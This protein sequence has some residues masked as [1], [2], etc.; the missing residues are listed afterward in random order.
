ME[1]KQIILTTL[2]TLVL[3]TGV[4]H[5]QQSELPQLNALKI[6]QIQVLGTHNSYARPVDPRLA[7]YADPI[8]AK[9]MEKMTTLI[10]ADK[11][12]SFKE[13]HPNPMT[14]SEGLKYDH[15]S[16]D[17]QLDS[18][19]RSL[20][21]DVYYDPTGH[22]FNKPAGYEV[23]NSMGVS[24]LAPYQKE[25]LE[26]PGFKMLHIADFDFR[27]HYATFRGGLKALRNWSDRHPGHLPIFIM[28]EAKDK[29]IPIFPNSAEVLPF[30]EK[31]FDLLDAEVIEIL[32]KDKLI[33]PDDV[34]GQYTTLREAV[35]SGNWPTI[36]TSRGKFVFLLLPA[37]AG[38]NLESAYVKDRPNLEKRIMFVQSEPNDSFA[39]FI[40][41]DNALVRQNEIQNLVKQGF[42]V[43]SRS[44]IETY[45]AKINDYTRADA[46]FN[47]G[48]QIISTD[49]FRPGNGYHTSYY[50]KLPHG[51]PARSNPINGRR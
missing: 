29:G 12:A 11:L 36:K 6:N 49:F 41:L 35:R 45:E 31:A 1:F 46:A 22:R 47:S 39:S 21:M 15:P 20:E 48:A 7:A 25:D 50:V 34:R 18:G 51:N 19:I 9:M 10:P 4:I 2:S 14:M 17:V 32:G 40:L 5:A 13:F 33:T 24:D 28:V 38:M 3:G 16:F 44:D 23:L 37:T 8:F 42:I 30:D 43:R 27:S 26:K